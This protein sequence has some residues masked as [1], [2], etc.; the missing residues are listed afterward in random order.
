M[1]EAIKKSYTYVI[2][3]KKGAPFMALLEVTNIKKTC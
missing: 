1:A 3:E 2:N